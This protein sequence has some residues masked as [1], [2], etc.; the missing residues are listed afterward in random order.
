MSR[1]LKYCRYV[2]LIDGGMGWEV[3]G[4]TFTQDWLAP[5]M[6]DLLVALERAGYDDW[7]DIGKDHKLEAELATTVLP[8]PLDKLTIGE[9]VS[10]YAGPTKVV[11]G[12]LVRSAILELGPEALEALGHFERHACPAEGCQGTIRV[13][14][15]ATPDIYMCP[16]GA[17][18]IHVR[19]PRYGERPESGKRFILEVVE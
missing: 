1:T 6:S 3:F 15:T 2:A 10:V 12:R 5:R 9:G 14:K 4:S 8:W 19:L 16:C 18:R 13:P 7:E 17:K 11:E